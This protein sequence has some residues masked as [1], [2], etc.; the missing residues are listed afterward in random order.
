MGGDRKAAAVAAAS[1]K[2]PDG[3]RNERE[4]RGKLM[5]TIYASVGRNGT[6]DSALIPNT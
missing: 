4:K 5:A 3:H 1:N 2:R 6:L